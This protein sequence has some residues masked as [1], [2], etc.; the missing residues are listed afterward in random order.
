MATVA[1][2]CGVLLSAFLVVPVYESN[3]DVLVRPVALVPTQPSR[4]ATVNLQV[5]RR[6]ASSAAVTALADAKLGSAGVTP[7]TISVDASASD[8]TLHFTAT[9]PDRVAAQQ[10]A[11]TFA[12]SYLELRQRDALEDLAAARRPLQTQIDADNRQLEALRTQILAARDDAQRAALRMQLDPLASEL[13]ALQQSL[14]DLV[15]PE[16]LR[17]GEVLRPANRPRSPSLPGGDR[18]TGAL[19][20]LVGLPLGVGLTLVRDRLDQQVRGPE[21]LEELAGAPVLAVVRRTARRG[22]PPDQV[23]V[24]LEAEAT[25]A[26][27]DLC[28]KVMAVAARSGLQFLTIASPDGGQ[29]TVTANLGVALAQARKRVI[30]VAA[31][32]GGS[33]LRQLFALPDRA[34]TD[35]PTTGSAAGGPRSLWE[36]CWVLHD[37]LFLFLSPEDLDPPAAS[38]LPGLRAEL[39]EAADFILVDGP[40]IPEMVQGSG[41]TPPTD[42]VLLV[43]DAQ[44]ASRASVRAAQRQLDQAGAVVVGAVLVHGTPRRKRAAAPAGALATSGH[45]TPIVLNDQGAVEAQLLRFLRSRPSHADGPPQRPLVVVT[46]DRGEQG[47]STVAADVAFTLAGDGRRVALVDLD[48]SHPT[49]HRILDLPEGVG[50]AEVA[51]D[52]VPLEQAMHRFEVSP[53]HDPPDPDPDGARPVPG[54][55]EVLTAGALPAGGEA[56]VTGPI[57]RTVVELVRE[58]ADVVLVDAPPMRRVDDALSLL[59]QFDA[60]V[61]VNGRGR[62]RSRLL[63]R[64]P[65]LDEQAAPNLGRELQAPPL[66]T[67][68]PRAGARIAET[69]ADALLAASIAVGGAITLLLASTD[70][71]TIVRPFV[72]LAF[73]GFAPGAAFVWLLRG[74]DLPTKIVASI[75]LSLAIGTMTAQAMIWLHAWSPTAG[76]VA[77][78]SLS[79]VGLVLQGWQWLRARASA[80]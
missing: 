24:D 42:G 14:H 53:E 29:A 22:G 69:R 49:Q 4:A 46:G 43:V 57:A 40:P 39:Q 18:M 63:D 76:L 32:P 55:V 8:S 20:L 3:A 65:V 19:V 41:L 58:R 17:V 74:L 13:L 9:A 21:E 16:N 7:G 23:T 56:V 72:T 11:Q 62:E 30:L 44:R 36:R 27:R 45:A 25:D 78:V 15:L 59:P 77:L 12:E 54:S 33:R 2:V 73:I 52:G 6:L 60:L 71:K 70:A 31:E 50:L 66:V 61:V 79:M 28:R 80:G 34:A 38:G 37:N 5:E 75:A 35:G 26:Y 47:K 1:A 10:T 64:P 51:L 48:L 68:A 67:R